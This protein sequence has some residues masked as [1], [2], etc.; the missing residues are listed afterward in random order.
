[1]HVSSFLLARQMPCD[2]H[3]TSAHPKA[4]PKNPIPFQLA[5]FQACWYLPPWQG[6]VCFPHG[7]C[8][9]RR[10]QHTLQSHSRS[11]F[12]LAKP[13][14]VLGISTVESAAN[15]P[16]RGDLL[17]CDLTVRGEIGSRPDPMGLARVEDTVRTWYWASRTLGLRPPGRWEARFF[18]VSIG[19]LLRTTVRST[20][21]SFTTSPRARSVRIGVPGHCRHSGSIHGQPKI[22]I[23]LT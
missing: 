18:S 3:S 1:M 16:E 6:S 17:P 14:V 11:I 13:K 7:R 8:H 22:K 4:L 21:S 20:A 12:D 10:K 2:L 15:T 9:P 23:A 19:D 5:F